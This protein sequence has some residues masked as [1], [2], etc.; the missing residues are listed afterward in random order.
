MRWASLSE[1]KVALTQASMRGGGGVALLG[2]GDASA[3]EPV[4]TDDDVGPDV[5]V[6]DGAAAQPLTIAASN[7][8]ASML[9][10]ARWRRGMRLLADRRTDQLGPVILDKHGMTVPMTDWDTVRLLDRPAGRQGR[11]AHASV[12]VRHLPLPSAGPS[13]RECGAWPASGLRA[14]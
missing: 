6:G 11:A 4:A 12:A 3:A 5:V 9:S 14:R 10:G 13:S 1:A 7:T 2:V 8:V